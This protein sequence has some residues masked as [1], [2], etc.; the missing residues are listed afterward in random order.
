MKYETDKQLL[1]AVVE[2]L[3]GGTEHFGKAIEMEVERASISS[4]GL[5][6]RTKATKDVL[7]PAGELD[8][9][10]VATVMDNLTSTLVTA[11]AMRPHVT[12]S[13]AVSTLAKPP[14]GAAIV[15]ECTLGS[16]KSQPQASAVFWSAGPVGQRTKFAVGSHTKFFKPAQPPRF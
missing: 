4:R 11:F 13:L 8:E 14:V 7:G 6:A 12:T 15:V 2:L 10:W 5:T 16:A 9:G 3:G 1:D